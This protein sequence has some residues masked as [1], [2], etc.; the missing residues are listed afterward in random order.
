MAD[1]EVRRDTVAEGVHRPVLVGD[2]VREPSALSVSC[3]GDWL[4]D[5]YLIG[6]RGFQ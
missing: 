1:Q 5:P 6:D 4:Q 3:L 2:R